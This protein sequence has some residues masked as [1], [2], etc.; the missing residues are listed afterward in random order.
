MSDIEKFY[1]S[2]RKQFPESRP[3]NELN[4]MQQMQV[5]QGANLILSVLWS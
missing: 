5:V 2:A 3:W 1:E 4:P